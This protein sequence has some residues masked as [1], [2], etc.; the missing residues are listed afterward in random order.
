MG[1][2]LTLIKTCTF[3]VSA[4]LP[5]VNIS[6]SFRIFNGFRFYAKIEFF[7]RK[8]THPTIFFNNLFPDFDN[9]TLS[10]I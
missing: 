1:G 9:R 4:R 10:K 7:F 5:N 2:V 6:L 8:T 3:S